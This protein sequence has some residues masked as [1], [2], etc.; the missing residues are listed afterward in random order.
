[1]LCVWACWNSFKRH[2]TALWKVSRSSTVCVKR[3]YDMHHR[4][5][6]MDDRRQV[7]NLDGVAASQRHLD[8]TPAPFDSDGIMDA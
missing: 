8:M 2:S 7:L 6:M 3:T 1:M 5:W 4:L